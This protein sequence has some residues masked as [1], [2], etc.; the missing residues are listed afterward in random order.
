MQTSRGNGRCLDNNAIPA[1]GLDFTTVS[2]LPGEQYSPDLQCQLALG[3]QYKA[4][5][6]A[7]QP[8]NVSRSDDMTN[9]SS[10]RR[11]GGGQHKSPFRFNERTGN[12]GKL[13]TSLQK[14]AFCVCVLGHLSRTVVSVRLVGDTRTP[15]AGRKCVQWS[16]RKVL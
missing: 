5:Y 1:P 15:G 10:A 9:D 11:R 7:K 4:Y 6:S 16:R 2:R 3:T 13:F 8:F 12:T 14:Y